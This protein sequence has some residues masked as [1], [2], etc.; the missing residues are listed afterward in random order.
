MV[1]LPR[2]P[3]HWALADFF[4]SNKCIGVSMMQ[5]LVHLYRLSQAQ[6]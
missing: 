2:C 1:L 3:F 4:F 5:A 6:A